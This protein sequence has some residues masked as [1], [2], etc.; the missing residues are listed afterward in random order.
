MVDNGVKFVEEKTS[1]LTVDTL[2]RTDLRF[3]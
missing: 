1:I 2:K 3:E